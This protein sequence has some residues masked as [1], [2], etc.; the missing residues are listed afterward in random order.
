MNRIVIVFILQSLFI[1]L[2]GQVNKYGVPIIRNYST[3]MTSGSEQ[4]WCIEQDP[5]GNV[6]FGN[7]DRGVIKYDGTQWSQIMIGNNPRIFSLTSDSRGVV[8]VGAAFEFGYLQPDM[9]GR[10]EYISLA[11]RV[12]S[13]PEIR[14]IYST[15]ISDNKVYF[16]GPKMIYIYDIN[17]D[18]L[19]KI[20]LKEYKLIDAIRLVKINDRLI[21]ADNLSG[22]F[23]LKDNTISPLPGGYFFKKMACTVLLPFDKTK[24]L[25]GTFYDGLFLYDYT[26]GEINNSFIDGKLN[27][28]LKEVSIYAGSILANDL[29]AIGTTNQEGILIF[30][31]T[32]ALVQQIKK[33]NSDLGDNTI[34]AMHCDPQRNSE[35]WISTQGIISKAYLN[36]PLTHFGEKQGVSSGLNH[37]TEFNGSIYLATDAGILKSKLNSENEIVFGEV[38]GTNTQVFPLDY[39]R[40]ASGD[41]LLAGSLNGILQISRNDFVTRVEQNC[42]NLPHKILKYNA[43]RFL[44]SDSDPSVVYV[45][46]MNGGIVVLKYSGSKWSYISSLKKISGVI[47][48]MIEKKEGGLW[49]FTDD[50]NSL[51]SATFLTNDTLL[52]EYGPDKGIPDS[53]I[54]SIN[55][56]MGELYVTTSAGILRYDK[57]SD[58]FVSDNA[59]TGGYSQG[60]NVSNLY[61]DSDQDLW[62]SGIDN[63]VTELLF[64]KNNN[65]VE[66]YSGVL[67]LLPNITML[68]IMDIDSK[69]YMLKS[70]S[71]FVAD[72]SKLLEDTTRVK[73]SFVRITAGTDSVV[74]EGTF[75]KT[76]NKNR[77]IPVISGSVTEVPEFG[78]D[79]N[80]LRFEWTTPNFTEELLIEYSYKLEGFDNDWSKWE[81]ISYGNTMAAQYSKKEYTNLPFGK[82]SF[83]VRTKTLTGLTGSSELSYDFIIL[84]PWYATLLAYVGFALIAFLLIVALIKAYT[85]KLKNENIRLEGIVAERTAVVVKQKEELE[86]SI[87]YASRIQMALLPSEAILSENIKNYFV[88]F[89]P[90]DIVS[91][92]F[93]W[94]TK[95]GERLYIVAADCTGHGVPGA[96]MSLLGMSFLD[97]IIDREITLSANT[98]LRELRLHVTESLK[99]VGSDDEAKD[100]MDLALLVIDFNAKKVEYSGAYN[101]C[102]KVRRLTE[103]ESNMRQTDTSD[104]A[105]GSMSDGKYILETIRASKMPIG[106]SSK[107]NEEFVFH[108]DPLEK[109]VSYYLFSD[110]YIDQFGGPNGR[111]F[112]KKN[113]KKF[114]LGI[115]DYS[116]TEQRDLLE[117][118]LLEWRGLSPQI[119]DILVM[120]IRID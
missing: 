15:I 51:F 35:L 61:I 59:L 98:I 39:I 110:G 23:E 22:L 97:E 100:G 31:K 13:T 24:I 83:K 26:T 12:D 2:S 60:R 1:S 102:F 81:G 36:I 7:Q 27:G 40:S 73:T 74:M 119:D 96:F 30:N 50:P 95:R 63:G 114:I 67:K 108:E 93:Y 75:Y 49:F 116:M 48:G 29:F 19:V 47:S 21:L 20:S 58:R 88:L 99:Q 56:I 92:D 90:R 4:N 53:D 115:Q 14:Y 5:F 11:A 38:S 55:T 80:E 64:R 89:R 104:D 62:Y 70:K 91:G 44:Q 65:A 28:K 106:I 9:K 43:S 107:M 17:N 42:L 105:D 113:F 79:M 57:N 112:M 16:Q 3:Q 46:L 71:L 77:R 32:G 85:R 84:K 86:S 109:G 10:T 120:G 66:S 6:Y 72:K 111:K 37:V 33:E 101:P 94:M 18:S 69:I 8:Y 78:Y 25:I 68:D 34:I 41:F 54:S 45:G 103:E 118:N 76:D 82:Y 52:T 117:K 87:H